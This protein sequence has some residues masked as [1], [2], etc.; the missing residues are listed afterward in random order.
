MKFLST[1]LLLTAAL[2]TAAPVEKLFTLVTSGSSTPAHNGLS[3]S[4]QSTGPLISNAVFR[5]TAN[6]ATFYLS[7][8]TVHYEAPNGAP[9]VL[10][11]V[12]GSSVQGG[13]EVSVSPS[14]AVRT[15]F[16]IA[17]D[18]G[19]RASSAT[20]GGWLVCPGDKDSGLLGLFYQDTSVG[21]G[22]PAGC[23]R[24][25]LRVVYTSS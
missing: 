8:S 20:W 22:V 6:A 13:V 1:A 14:G 5:D 12:G 10:A 7:N 25:Q 11:L 4:T 19:L 2:T 24:V 16:R 3:L 17:G 21:S 23:D 9:Y 18:G 15:G